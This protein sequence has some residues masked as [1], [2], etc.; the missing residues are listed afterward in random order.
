MTALNPGAG[1]RRFHLRDGEYDPLILNVAEMSNRLVTI[2]F[3][4][5]KAVSHSLSRM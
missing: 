4:D 3:I 1:C 2:R 5:H